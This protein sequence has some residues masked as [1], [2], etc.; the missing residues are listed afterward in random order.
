MSDY[1][2]HIVHTMTIAELLSRFHRRPALY[3]LVSPESADWRNIQKIG[4]SM[5]IPFR[6]NPWKTCSI[7][8]VQFYHIFFLDTAAFPTLAD[9]VHLDEVVLP[10]WLKQRG[11][12]LDMHVYKGGGTEFFRFPDPVATLREFLEEHGIR[13]IEE[14]SEDPFP[15]PCS[16]PDAEK[17][18]LE[19]EDSVRTRVRAS[20][21]QQ[22]L[23]TVLCKKRFLRLFGLQALRQ[24]Q[25]E[26]WDA[27]VN[28]LNTCKTY[29]GIVQWPTG[30]GKTFAMLI[31][32]LLLH[33]HLQEKGQ[34]YRGI[35]VA[36]QNNILDTLMKHIR[37]LGHWG[38]Q[39][40]EGHNAKFS[41]LTIPND[42]PFLLVTT[43]AAL[44]EKTA[45]DRIP[46]LNHIHYD[47]VHR[48]TGEEFYEAAQEKIATWNIPYITGTSATPKTSDPK[49]HTK[50]ARLFGA[51]EPL[52]QV[53]VERAVEAGWIA[54]PHFI[55]VS[56]KGN[57]ILGFLHEIRAFLESRTFQ[58]GKVIVY[59]EEKELVREALRQTAAW[60]WRRFQAL[61]EDVGNAGVIGTDKDF[62]ESE[63][64]SIPQLLFACQKYRE[65]SDISGIDAVAYL[66]G[67]TSSAHIIEQIVGRA[68]RMDYDGK[69]ATCLLARVQQEGET[70]DTVLEH[71]YLTMERMY[72][73]MNPLAPR[74]PYK[75][76]PWSIEWESNGILLSAEESMMHLQ[77]WYLR[78]E[79]SASEQKEKYEVVQKMNA[80]IG[81]RSKYEY[82]MRKSEHPKY[83][84]DPKRYFRDSWISWYHYLG[85]DT[86][87]FPATKLE[88]IGKCRELGIATWE[89]YKSKNCPE[90]P[91]N[92]GELYEDFTNWDKE[93]GVENEY[94]W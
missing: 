69:V 42:K 92:P 22:A 8:P 10:A 53:T 43:H 2:F 51:C 32:I 87:A 30:T 28:L 38:I 66:M 17:K 68:M 13:V 88:W 59:L 76:H 89:D 49:Q 15:F 62:V 82:E 71:V 75:K 24:N 78:K 41:T 58:K 81:I 73:G 19:E 35:L 61:G 31:L 21:N 4:T 63:P 9:L 50:L 91:T 12:W 85:I 34:V 11:E 79:Y 33:M 52:H 25:E 18:E 14:L 83:I 3:V 54:P 48:I 90:L 57:A 67:I 26:L 46:S 37:K 72:P 47:E 86:S 6:K 60:P 64:T 44:A 7:F 65:G 45:W 20:R 23:E 39:V 93:F 84:E 80:V 5:S 94:I 16:V 29:K 74:N 40:L 27:W 1:E 77:N 55:A 70:E 56:L 36:P